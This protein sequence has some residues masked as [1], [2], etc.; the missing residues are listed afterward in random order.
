MLIGTTS[1]SL[2]EWV[3]P[4]WTIVALLI[5][6]TFLSQSACEPCRMES[7]RGRTD[8]PTLSDRGLYGANAA[9]VPPPSELGDLLD[10]F[11]KVANK[12]PRGLPGRRARRVGRTEPEP[13]VTV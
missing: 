13:R 2:I 7:A 5:A 3:S 1:G 9:G 12:L 8:S 11:C 10:D 4:P 6:S